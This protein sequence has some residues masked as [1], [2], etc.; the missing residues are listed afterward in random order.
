M[1]GVITV[2]LLGPTFIESDDVRVFLSGMS[3]VLMLILAV[4]P[5]NTLT[6]A[7]IQRRAWPHLEPDSRTAARLRSLVRDTRQQ[8]IANSAARIPRASFPPYRGTIAGGTGYSLGAAQTD[9][10]TFTRLSTQARVSLQRGN[11]WDAWRQSGSAL[12]L[13]RGVPLQDAGPRAFALTHI[14]EF[15]KLRLAAQNTRYEAAIT[16]GMHRENLHALEALA[17]SWPADYGIIC[18]LVTALA[19]CGQIAEASDACRN[20][21]KHAIDRGIPVEPYRGLQDDLMDGKIPLSGPPWR[22]DLAM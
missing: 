8:L 7:D 10:D 11:V 21:I 19:R 18:L 12:G 3:A 20:A 9:R 22:P 1:A 15:E 2:G 13:V 14:R 16:L 6:S 17:A 4:T 5:G